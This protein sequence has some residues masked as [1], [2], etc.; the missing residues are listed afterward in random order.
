MKNLIAKIGTTRIGGSSTKPGYLYH[1]IPFGKFKSHRKGSA[2]K[3]KVI[4]SVY[5]VKEKRGLDI[6]C[7]VGG[8]T[9][10]LQLLG[11]KMVGIDYDGFSINFAKAVEEEEKTG[12]VFV[13]SKINLEFFQSLD[14]GFYDFTIWFSQFMWAEKQYGLKI[15]E[16]MLQI[17]S[18]K[19]NVL[20]F[21]TSQNDGQAKGSIKTA[22]D[23]YDL[24]RK[25]TNYSITDLG[26]VKD[27]KYSRNIFYCKK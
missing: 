25:N 4:Q 10:N 17:L 7:S 2:L 12:A 16:K 24:L 22:E 18:K 14:P 5:R 13:F 23:V 11:A 6:G 8:I 20:F 15:A 1:D 19:I 9:F 27:G 26:G 3:S 21:Q